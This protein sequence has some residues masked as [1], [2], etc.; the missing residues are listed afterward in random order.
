[1]TDRADI[2]SLQGLPQRELAESYCD[3]AVNAM[4][5][6]QER[7]AKQQV[8]P[9]R[10]PPSD[11]G[12]AEEAQTRTRRGRIE[13]GSLETKHLKPHFGALSFETFQPSNQTL[14]RDICGRSGRSGADA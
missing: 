14:V 6:L 4:F 8:V 9:K 3:R 12:F 2:A 10:A 7:S 11:T 13:S 1:M 5:A